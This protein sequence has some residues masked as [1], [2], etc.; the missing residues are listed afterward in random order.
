[1]ENR[2]SREQE[3]ARRRKVRQLRQLIMILEFVL[4]IILAISLIV[5]ST[6]YNNLKNETDLQNS[7]SVNSDLSPQFTEEQLAMMAE[8]DKWYLKLVNPDIAVDNSFIS[9]VERAEINSDYSSGHEAS[10]Y[11]DKRVLKS[12]EDMC[13]AAESDGIKIWAC[14]AYRT[15]SY[16]QSLYINKVNRLKNSGMDEATAKVEAA[17]VVALPGTS[18]HHLGLA[19]DINS[20]EESFENTVQFAWLQENAEDF[21]FILRYTKD[22]QS[23]T[24]IIY[25]PWHYR[26]VG[27]EHAKEINRLGM[28][29]EE[30]I[31]YL[32]NGG[33]QS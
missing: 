13:K 12:F 23:V 9:S 27:V 30:Y 25:E 4:I 10:K 33:I 21:G 6:K 26:Y 28:C 20:V 17:K 32:K 1:M 29:L 15:Y 22:K 2:Y 5:V 31:E 7:G 3:R 14:S 24:K 16:Q 11:L 19:V 8:V 18:E